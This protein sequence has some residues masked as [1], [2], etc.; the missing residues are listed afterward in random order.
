MCVKVCTVRPSLL[1]PDA[2]Q[3]IEVKRR[4]TNCRMGTAGTKTIYVVTS[5]SPRQATP[6]K[7]PYSTAGAGPS[8]P[9]TTS[10]T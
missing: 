6:A 2:L 9:C 7:S 3:A 8:R 10:G 5:L 4:R 1:F